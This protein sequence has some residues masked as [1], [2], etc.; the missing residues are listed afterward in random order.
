MLG[1]MILLVVGA[2]LSFF[3]VCGCA[4]AKSSEKNRYCAMA[5][6]SALIY[7]FVS[8][9]ILYC[10]NVEQ[11]VMLQKLS[12]TS[13]LYMLIGSAFAI[14]Y[15]F[16]V[17]YSTRVKIIITL[18]SFAFVIM[19]LTFNMSNPW[20][21]S[22]D[23]NTYDDQL[24]ITFISMKGGW[25]YYVLNA[26]VL[27]GFIS[28]IVTTI[29]ITA[30]KKG[31]EFKLFRYLLGFAMFPLFIWI[32]SVFGIFK[33]SICNEIIFM[34]LLVLVIHVEIFFSFSFQPKQYN[35]LLFKNSS[36]GIIVLD[37]KKRYVYANNSAIDIFDIF[38]KGNKD[39]ITA[40]INVN[41]IGEQ[42]YYDGTDHYSIKLETISNDDNPREGYAVW[43]EKL[44][45][46]NTPD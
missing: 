29:I 6:V 43:V 27:V 23:P 39:A 35:D 36:K 26:V 33:S 32:F 11:F 38:A 30:S 21:K 14:G 8:F 9:L 24:G 15:I 44:E 4:F 5:S 3:A 37:Y 17:E 18:I 13:G 16:K 41:L 22:Y 25:F 46:N 45:K 28:W 20:V 12:L 1:E 34:L 31:R 7:F 10:N 19:F 40:F 42:S 2:V